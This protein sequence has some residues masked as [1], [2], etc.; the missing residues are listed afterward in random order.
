MSEDPKN[1][2]PVV[3]VEPTK[4]E[5]PKVDSP[6]VS[7]ESK[8][9]ALIAHLGG[10]FTFFIA[11]LIIYLVKT[12]D[13]FVQEEAK[14]AL[15]FQIIVSIALLVCNILFFLIIPLILIPIIWIISLVFGV[16]ASVSVADGK[17]YKYPFNFRLIK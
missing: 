10:V 5:T 16:I 7:Q 6:I 3:N 15:N 8:N 13:K 17:V 1:S 11:P 2:T 14:E 9:F 4:T 12:D